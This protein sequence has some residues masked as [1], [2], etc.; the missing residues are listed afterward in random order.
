MIVLAVL[1]LVVRFAPRTD[2]VPLYFNGLHPTE[3]ETVGEAL[4]DRGYQCLIN[5]ETQSV[6]V[7]E[8]ELNAA[9]ASLAQAGLPR[10]MGELRK[11]VFV[12]DH[13]TAA[14]EKAHNQ[15]RLEA[16]LTNS[17]T[18]MTGVLDARVTIALPGKC[19][20][21]PCPRRRKARVLVRLEHPQPVEAIRGAVMMIALS[22][23]EM[24]PDDIKIIDSNMTDLTATVEL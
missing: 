4:R 13:R 2:F 7:V 5:L 14:V 11:R 15:R 17:L 6:F 22:V 23:P 9:R 8:E 20:W 19:C 10:R 16:E 1:A 21:G 24:K 18:L 3:V 12:G